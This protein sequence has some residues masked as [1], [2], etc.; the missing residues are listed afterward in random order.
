MIYSVTSSF[1]D[2]WYEKIFTCY[3]HF[4]FNLLILKLNT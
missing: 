4:R 1:R 3:I 2:M